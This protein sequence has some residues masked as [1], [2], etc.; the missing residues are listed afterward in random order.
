MKN[1]KKRDAPEYWQ[2]LIKKHP[3]L[4]FDNLEPKFKQE[5]IHLKS[6]M[7]QNEQFYL[8]CYC[9]KCI[10]E[11]HSHI[12]HFKPR[13]RSPQLSMEYSNMLISCT[14]NT[15]GM[16]KGCKELPASISY[17]DW[18]SR[19]SY[20]IDGYIKPKENDFDAQIAIDMLNLND[21][22]LIQMR[23][24]VYDECLTVAVSIGKE[25]VK[26]YYIDIDN[27]HLPRFS[28]MIEY[29][30]NLGHFDEDVVSFA[31]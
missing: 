3:Y 31:E 26:K 11:E 1:I 5:K 9:C 7:L 29:F 4:T 25:N 16:K 18:E 8:C 23:R 14:S 30:Y 19:F 17:E 2:A 6:D 27:G 22:S 28:Q 24:V 12:E 15:C 20:T 10:D 21:Q 13:C